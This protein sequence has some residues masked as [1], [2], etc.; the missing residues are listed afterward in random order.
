MFFHFLESA[1]SL[2]TISIFLIFSIARLLILLV[3][4]TFLIH[5]LLPAFGV[6]TL[7]LDEIP[8]LLDFALF[9]LALFVKDP[10]EELFLLLVD[11]ELDGLL[12]VRHEVDGFVLA[13]PL[14]LLR[15]R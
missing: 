5:E 12:D 11:D 8:D 13:H 2:V 1:Y 3:F 14:F 9:L 10:H 15:D 4:L 7:E 6:F